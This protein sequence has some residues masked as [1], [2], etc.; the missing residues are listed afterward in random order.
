M[1][2]IIY[3]DESGTHDGSDFSL[4]AGWIAYESVWNEIIPAWQ[5]VLDEYKVEH[6]HFTE[7][8]EASSVKRNPEKEVKSTY[9]SN[10][11]TRV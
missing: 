4:L 8:A 11:L 3:A 6:F 5:A 2:L 9:E 1:E 10:V 7:F